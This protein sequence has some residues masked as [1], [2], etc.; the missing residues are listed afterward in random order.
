MKF[1]V[2]CW[3]KIYCAILAAK[4]QMTCRSENCCGLSRSFQNRN[5]STHLLKEFRDSHNHMAI[6]VDEYGG[7]AGLLTIEDVLEEIVGEIDDEH[8]QGRGRLHSARWRQERQT[9]LCRAR[10]D[11]HRGL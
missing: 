1:S 5:A 9:K 4:R 2:C 7:V 8:D 6:V 10:I 11:A 3:P